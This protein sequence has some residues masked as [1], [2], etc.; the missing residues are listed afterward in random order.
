MNGGNPL[1]SV[2]VPIYNGEPFMVQ[3]LQSVIVQ[4]YRPLEIIVVDD[5]STD[6]TAQSVRTISDSSDVPLRYVFQDNRGPAA[7][8]NRGV[9]IAHGEIIAFQDADD[10]WADHK[11]AT[12]VNLLAEHPAASVVLGY[13]RVVRSTDEGGLE[14]CPGKGGMPGLVTVLQAALFRRSIF[15][16]VGLLDESLLRGEDVDWYLR[17]LEQKTQMVVHADVVLLYRRHAA[18]LTR[19]NDHVSL[20]LALKRS[21]SRRRDRTGEGAELAP[22]LRR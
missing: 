14:Q 6:G 15:E 21:L 16:R 18:N 5:G 22:R 1:V 4:D 2:V 9:E 7:A 17:A 3:A 19:D 12:Q 8:R 11:L 20:L 10:V 13:T